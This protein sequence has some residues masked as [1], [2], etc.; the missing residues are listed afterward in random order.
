M[1]RS[2]VVLVAGAVVA[3]ALAAGC[4]RAPSEAG[5]YESRKFGFSI[6]LPDGWK[7][8]P[9]AV[10]SAVTA[11]SPAE[12]PDDRYRENV[13]VDV[14]DVP[15]AIDLEKYFE[16]Y[17]ANL[18]PYLPPGEEPEIGEADLGGRPARRV[19]YH[20]LI[21]KVRTRNVVYVLVEG[22]RAYTIT[23]VAAPEAFEAY[24]AEFR[25]IAES[26]RVE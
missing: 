4:S 8:D 13:G 20:M 23:C 11:F 24:E 12:G 21:G 16:A 2:G 19:A 25:R 6:V 9:Q 14:Q 22:R 1:K 17:M 3:S 7:T 18:A 26:F 15:E 5:R 10:G